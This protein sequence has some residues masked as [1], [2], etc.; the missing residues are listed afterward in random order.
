MFLPDITPA[1]ERPLH[2][3]L[4]RSVHVKSKIPKMTSRR[5]KFAKGGSSVE[6]EA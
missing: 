4:R 6:L 3:W 5:Y 2:D 1:G